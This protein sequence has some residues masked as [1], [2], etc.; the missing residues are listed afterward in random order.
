M[1][2]DIIS[3]DANFTIRALAAGE[4]RSGLRTYT[5]SDGD[6]TTTEYQF[7][8]TIEK[9][10][11]ENLTLFGQSFSTDH[12]RESCVGGPSGESAVHNDYWVQQT[13]GLIRKS[14]QW[15]GPRV[16]YFQL[17]VVKQ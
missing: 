14:R 15:M 5:I 3:A 17:I 11:P 8:C 9:V 7:R 2:G 1:G 4:N 13:D 10:K 12:M 6:V 16:G